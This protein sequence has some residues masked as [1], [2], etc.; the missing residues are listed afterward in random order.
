MVL[1]W[2]GYAPALYWEQNF[3]ERGVFSMQNRFPNQE[4]ARAVAQSRPPRASRRAQP[5]DGR[6]PLLLLLCAALAAVSLF[7]FL[8]QRNPG[9]GAGD[10]GAQGQPAPPADEGAAADA[11]SGEAD[12]LLLLVNPWTPLPAGHTI[13]VTQLRGG[14]AIDQRCYPALQ[15][16]MDAC[17]AEGHQPVICSSYRPHNKQEALFANKVQRLMAAGYDAEEADQKAATVVARPGT[18]EH[19]LGLAVD[20]VDA[21]YQH[22]DEQQESTPVQQWLMEHCWEYGFILR[23]PNGKSDLTGIIYEPWHYRYVGVETAQALRESGQCLEEYLQA[24]KAS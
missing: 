19:E 22:L 12:G 6:A 20:I 1:Q 18:S 3:C 15:A 10:G 11:A 7:A 5:V 23:Y 14:Q 24:A 2:G 4:P 16:M 8:S 9:R 17:R 13:T 21:S